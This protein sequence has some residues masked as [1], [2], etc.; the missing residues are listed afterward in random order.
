MRFRRSLPIALLPVLLA[1]RRAA[2]ACSRKGRTARDAPQASRPE[3]TAAAPARWATSSTGWPGSWPPPMPWSWPRSTRSPSVSG[4][5]RP[6][7]QRRRRRRHCGATSP[8]WS[9]S[10]CPGRRWA[11]MWWL[12]SSGT[13]DHA[14]QSGFEVSEQP[15]LYPGDRAVF[16]R[17]RNND[18]FPIPD[19]HSR[20]VGGRRR[21]GGLGVRPGP[22]AGRRPRPEPAGVRELVLQART[23]GRSSDPTVPERR[24]PNSAD[25]GSA[26][27]SGA[28]SSGWPGSGCRALLTRD[29]RPG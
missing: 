15:W 13:Y 12:G 25:S 14:G 11:I 24:R 8:S 7:R 23:S 26:C 1:S 9:P 28:G 20:R 22:G 19:P 2:A 3:S 4:I 6:A 17:Q 10:S 29:D 21:R 18:L 16:S 5:S 27:G